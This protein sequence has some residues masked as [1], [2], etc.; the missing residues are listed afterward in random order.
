MPFSV[1]DW[2]NL[3]STAT[4]LNAA[5]IKDV[6]A[7]LSG[8]TDARVSVIHAQL[9]HGAVG[10]GTAN[11]RSALNDAI[12]D[13]NSRSGPAVL[14]IP[15]PPVEYL[16]D[17]P[18]HSVTKSFGAIIGQANT[19]INL[20]DNVGTFFNLG[21]VGA[22]VNKL[23]MD[24]LLLKCSGTP[25]ARAI[26]APDLDD[27]TIRNLRVQNVAGLIELG[28]TAA[29]S[30]AA[31]SRVHLINV[32]GTIINGSSISW[33]RLKSA[34]G[35]KFIGCHL[36]S[37]VQTSSGQ[38]YVEV[39]GGDA[40]SD[41]NDFIGC[42]F[43]ANPGAGGTVGIP[44]S[45]KIDATLGSVNSLR[46]RGGTFDGS[47]TAA[48]YY[49]GDSSVATARGHS[50]LGARFETASGAIVDFSHANSGV[51]PFQLFKMSECDL[52][53]G[54]GGNTATPFTFAG[55]KV[56]GVHIDGNDIYEQGSGTKSRIFLMGIS[57][58]SVRGNAVRKNSHSSTV[59]D[60]NYAFETNADVDR[61]VTADN[62]IHPPNGGQLRGTRGYFKHFAY[63]ADSVERRVLDFFDGSARRPG[64]RIAGAVASTVVTQFQLYYIRLPVEDVMRVLG[65]AYR[66]GATS[67]GNV[68]AALWD[69]RGALVASSG[70]T[71]AASANADQKV[72]FSSAAILNPGQYFASVISDSATHTM[73]MARLH[74]P[75]GLAAQ[76]SL[77]LPASITPPS[78]AN[79]APMPL[80]AIY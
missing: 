44:Y 28:D 65:I 49:R 61:F 72:D 15:S 75:C 47:D 38:A 66:V 32:N 77:S 26:V 29:A 33:A 43:F 46:V 55:A 69:A 52:F 57:D 78:N 36:T 71:V 41:T 70:S 2:Q 24:G 31:A 12:D 1:K 76:G 14:L 53:F 13:Y 73:N 7:R 51:N 18:L 63:A 11:D 68:M 54:N 59:I 56:S 4:K 35:C 22:S 58:W 50:I 39:G 79:A 62:I 19:T 30:A 48:W 37:G 17:G 23:T 27:A 40:I 5:G 6:E 20:T 8:Y 67:N 74:A 3:P 60:T 10:N 42:V 34:A 45:F 16:I 9:D 64:E 25:T 80:L 21:A